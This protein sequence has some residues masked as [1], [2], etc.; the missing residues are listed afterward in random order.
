MYACKYAN[1]IDSDSNLGVQ[2][3][4]KFQY[5]GC[6]GA[7]ASSVLS[8]Q[9]PFLKSP[10]MVT[11]SVGGNDADFAAVLNWCVHQWFTPI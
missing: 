4:R 11:L 5:L 9:V 10:Q 1:V 7:V 2:P 3:T 6:S 8:D